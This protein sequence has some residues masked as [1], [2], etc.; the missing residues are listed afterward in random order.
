MA[1]LTPASVFRRFVTDGVPSSGNH[2]PEKAE[3]IQLLNLFF[4][5]SRGGWV[6]AGTKAELDGVTPENETDGGVVLNDPTAS[7]NGYY[8]RDASAWVR[9]R[10]F[11]DTFARVTLGGTANAQTGAVSSAVNPGDIEVFIAFVTTANTGAMT[12]SVDGETARDVVNVAGNAL[13]AGEWTGVVLFVLNDDGDYQLILDAGAAASAA[14]SASEAADSLAEFNEKYLG[15]YADD[16][17]ATSAAGGSPVAGALYWSTSENRL[18][19][20]G[21]SAWAATDVALADGAVTEPKLATST[22]GKLI[23]FAANRTALAQFD[24]TTYQAVDLMEAGR[25]GQF[26]WDG[27]DLSA[28]VSADTEQGLYVAPTSDPTGASGAWVRKFNNSVDPRWYGAV[29]SNLALDTAAFQAAA[30][31]G[32]PVFVSRKATLPYLV[33]NVRLPNACEIYAR[34][35]GLPGGYIGNAENFLINGDGTNPIFWV[36]TYSSAVS[37]PLTDPLSVTSG[38]AVV[39]VAHTAHGFETGQT[40]TVSGA[41]AI[42]GITPN[43]SNV[44]ITVLDANTYTYTFTSDATSTVSDGGGSVYISTP[45]D[46]RYVCIH[47]LSAYNDGAPCLELHNTPDFRVFDN[48]FTAVNLPSG[49]ACVDIRYSVRG[50]LKNNRIAGGDYDGVGGSFGWGIQALDNCN[51]GDFSGNTVTGGSL[52]GAVNVGQTQVLNLQNTTIESCLTGFQIGTD[53]GQCSAIDISDFYI[54]QVRSPFRLG[55]TYAVNG[56]V[57][58]GGYVGNSV[59][60][61]IADRFPCWIIGRVRGLEAVGGTFYGKGTEDFLR[62]F[63]SV[64]DPTEMIR[65]EIRPAFRTGYAND[66]T[67]DASISD[68]SKTRIMGNN[69]IEL[70]ETTVY[71]SRKEWISPVITC[72]AGLAQLGIVPP[73]TNGGQ[74]ESVQIV[75][76]SGAL[77]GTLR[78][79]SSTNTAEVV[80]LGLAGQPLSE[81]TLSINL[82]STRW[83][84]PGAAL[85]FRHVA[86]AAATSFQVR[87]VYRN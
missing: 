13:S 52:G 57:A 31:S 22:K 29:G 61:V 87:V 23:A 33:G 10:G 71:G 46:R 72:N 16:A 83:I 56:L 84:R 2:K 79:G 9:E 42:G 38:S 80:F 55:L 49:K 64:S 18:K 62:F 21:G 6:V 28:E 63:N 77:D 43:I 47:G 11:P 65:S 45:T 5:T 3:I 48:S 35:Y 26:F 39:N 68:L 19:T 78:I 7:N 81:N 15:A 73:T 17:S 25:K 37:V 59:T 67:F 27:S 54:E 69:L 44:S 53:S 36:G 8:Q 51:G 20:W 12:L 74:V 75:R 1:V 76:A 85:L 34:T 40:I 30:D 4:G 58:K 60:S 41:S 50:S 24:G 70:G 86:G 32:Y 66:V 14:Q 82:G